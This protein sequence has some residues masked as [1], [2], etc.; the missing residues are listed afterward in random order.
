MV[1]ICGTI[2]EV[3]HTLPETLIDD[4]YLSHMDV[5]KK[6]RKTERREAM[7]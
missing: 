5:V 6:R 4:S 1:Y 7:E 2:G 3:L